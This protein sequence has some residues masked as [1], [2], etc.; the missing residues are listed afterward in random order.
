M[1]KILPVEM[2]VTIGGETYQH[3][4][5]IEYESVPELKEKLRELADKLAE[6]ITEIF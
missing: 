1:R 5:P 3:V 4:M 6:K 2:T